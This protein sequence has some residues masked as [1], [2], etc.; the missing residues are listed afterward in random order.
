[1]SVARILSSS[2][3]LTAAFELIVNIY[4]ENSR[5]LFLIITNKFWT[6]NYY[7]KKKGAPASYN[8]DA[9]LLILI[10]D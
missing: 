2:I 8:T 3:L 10:K 5:K 9:P 4:I 7:C 1:M 6:M